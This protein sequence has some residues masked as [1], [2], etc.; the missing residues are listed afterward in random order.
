MPRGP[1]YIEGIARVF[2]ARNYLVMLMALIVSGITF[3]I[4]PW[5][6]VLVG[7]VLLALSMRLMGGKVL[8]DIAI[9][10]PG[11]IHFEGPNVFVD[12]IHFM[13]LAR[14]EVRRII[15]D[16]G[17]GVIIEP[18]DDDARAILA[19]NGQRMAI[20][21]DASIQL[22]IYKDVDTAE[23]TPILRRNLDSGRIGLLIVPQEPDIEYLVEAV[24]RVPI[25]ESAR[26]RPLQSRPGRKAAD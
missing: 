20:A 19:N 13:N 26:S 7:V 4:G 21:H 14:E 16:R 3:L 8:S 12:E 17:L 25:L 5:A 15:M 23:F 18:K 10:R 9:V 11:A 2:E 6:G 22:G 24:K 1:D